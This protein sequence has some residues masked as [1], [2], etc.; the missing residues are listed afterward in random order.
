[1]LGAVAAP[2]V[3]AARTCLRLHLYLRRVLGLDG[4]VCPHCGV[5]D[6]AYKLEG[7]RPNRA[8]RTRKAKSGAACGGAA[9]AASSSP[10]AKAASQIRFT[11][12]MA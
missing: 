7:V 11:T 10:R 12:P 5:V 3:A 9:S 4:P 2:A 6:S 8:R 1:M